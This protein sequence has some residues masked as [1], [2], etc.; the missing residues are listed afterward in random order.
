MMDLDEDALVCDFAETYQIYDYRSLP[1]QLVATLAAGLRDNSRIKLLQAKAPADL[2]TMILAT[3]ADNLSLLRAGMSKDKHPKPFLFTEAIW[4]EI[5]KKSNRVL[6][7][8]TPEAFEEALA[9]I[10]GA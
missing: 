6:S 8:D 3:I 2:E 5:R 9:R 1:L 7:F 10:K 4:E